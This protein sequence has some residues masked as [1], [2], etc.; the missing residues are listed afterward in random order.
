MNNGFDRDWLL[1]IALASVFLFHGIG[2]FTGAGG[3]GGFAQMTGLPV[4]MAFLVGFAE[5]AGGLGIIIGGFG[6]PLITRLAGAV[7]IPVMLGAIFM[8]HWGRWSF[9]P[10]ETHPMG[11]MEF[12]VVLTLIAAWFLFGPRK[13]A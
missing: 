11:G 10:S 7:I 4:V 6:K 2:K 12:Q 9:T 8:V 13:T 5:V 1:R 3:I